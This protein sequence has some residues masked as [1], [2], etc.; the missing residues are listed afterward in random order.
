MTEEY[1]PE[2]LALM[3][4]ALKSYGAPTPSKENNVHTFLSE[5]KRDK[6]TTKVGFLKGEEVGLAKFSA[7]SLQELSL[8][9]DKL[10]DDDTM[11]TIFK[12]ES[13]ILTSTSLSANGFLVRAAITQKKELQSERK[14]R[15]ENKGWFK[16][17]K[18]L[19]DYSD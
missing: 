7:R 16:A 18:Q 4:E 6:D 11:K 15:Q 8:L 17:K 19:N 3:E 5:V 9:S 10:C 12:D 13:E 2:E 14:E 1:T